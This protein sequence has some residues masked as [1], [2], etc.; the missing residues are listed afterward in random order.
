MS[1]RV[2]RVC[3]TVL[4]T[5]NISRSYF[6]NH[7]WICSSCDKDRLRIYNARP[8]VKK[9]NRERYMERYR[10]DEEYRKKRYASIRKYTRKNSH[11]G[12]IPVVDCLDKDNPVSFTEILDRSG[13]GRLYARKV[14][15]D[16]VKIGLVQYLKDDSYRIVPDNPL[17]FALDGYYEEAKNMKNRRMVVESAR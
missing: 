17:R 11:A 12:D 4:T 16:M 13:A 1:E 7:N 15:K 14:L 9:R 6:R 10:N 5:E 2:C 3:K 8:E